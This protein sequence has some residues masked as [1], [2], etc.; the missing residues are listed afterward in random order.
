MCHHIAPI[1]KARVSPN[2]IRPGGWYPLTA[3]KDPSLQEPVVFIFYIYARYL[4]LTK[5][6]C[7]ECES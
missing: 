5:G 3:Q 4:E 2:A 7:T 6:P 1:S